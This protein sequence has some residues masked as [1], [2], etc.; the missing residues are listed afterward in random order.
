MYIGIV[1]ITIYFALNDPYLCMWYKI[2]HN[3]QKT[4]RAHKTQY[5]RLTGASG[6]LYHPHPEGRLIALIT[7]IVCLCTLT[8]HPDDRHRPTRPTR[9]EKAGKQHLPTTASIADGRQPRS[10]THAPYI[11]RS[12]AHT[13]G[14]DNGT[15]PNCNYLSSLHSRGTTTH[16]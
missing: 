6:K 9:A 3:T 5:R 16:G 15:H 8:A 4:V 10:T 14:T 13:R 2:P 1:A 7:Q 12:A 11:I